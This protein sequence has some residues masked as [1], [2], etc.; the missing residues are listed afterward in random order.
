MGPL[1]LLCAIDL[2]A[3]GR[4]LLRVEHDGSPPARH[5]AELLRRH[6]VLMAGV[7]LPA[8]GSGPALRFERDGFPGYEIVERDGGVLVRGD[9]PVRAAY[10]LIEGWG[11]RF[12]EGAAEVPRAER[13][14]LEA[15]TA[16]RERVLFVEAGAGAGP[17]PYDPSLPAQGAAV[18]GLDRYRMEDFAAARELG[19]E[20]RVASTTFDD[21]LPVAR[22]DAHPEWFALRDGTRVPRGNFALQNPEARA[23]YLD[24]LAAW[25]EAHPEV[26]VVGLWPEVTTVWDEEALAAGAPESY[27]LLYRE[28]AARFPGRRFEILATGL[29]L[30]P[31]DGAVPASVEVRFRPG[32]EA[33][34]L[35]GVA[36]QEV[37][38]VAR[39]WEARGARLVLE[40]DAQ[41]ASWC[42]MPWPC[43]DAIRS[44]AARFRAAVLV[45]GGHVHARLWRDPSAWSPPAP[46][47]SLL[48]KARTVRS[49]GHPSDAADLFH[50]DST[51]GRIGAVERLL[52]VAAHPEGD[53]EAR[54]TA[55]ADA[56]LAFMAVLRDLAPEHR[57]AYRL[58][59]AREVRR[60]FEELLPGGVAYEVGPARVREDL[61]R[62]EVETDRLRLVIERARAVVVEVR[63][64]VGAE[65][66]PDLTGGDGQF[67]GVV[68][69]EGATERAD[70]EVSLHSPDTG[71]LRVELSGRLRESGPRWS[72]VLDL[73]SASG[74]VRQTARVEADGG[75]AAGCRW[76]GQV[77]D[78]WVCPPYAVEGRLPG[79]ERA[80]FRLVPGT[81]LYCRHGEEGPGLALRA[82]DGA[83]ATLVPGTM[84]A[85]GR[86]RTLAVD[87]IL[88]TDPGELGR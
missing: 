16:R 4:A 86:G 20:V 33:S 56:Y 88:F 47:H 8:E 53:R 58:H 11:C 23:A 65:W 54:A 12:D 55:L 51:A 84:A 39:A 5:A 46:L 22:F 80:T 28:A 83:L 31:P 49:W 44:N 24:G 17:R 18:R 25:L 9:D 67:F 30:R 87:W 68:A 79:S 38:L 62:V 73:S 60:L 21:F 13:L 42:G 50:D 82:P 27:A 75:I 63:R 40:I 85:T 61:D 52:R 36:G 81:L 6:V 15:R 7:A 57:A 32:S 78:R 19:Y 64:K 66:S 2:V 70:G 10:D 37:D 45:G 72:S 26:S 43:H 59:R 41:P 35:Q 14:S 74:K 1:V 29:T 71:L 3:D 48:E 76:R 77:F 34:G 69:L